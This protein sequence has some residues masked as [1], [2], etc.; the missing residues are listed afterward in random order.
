MGEMKKNEYDIDSYGDEAGDFT[1]RWDIHLHTIIGSPCAAY[2]PLQIPHYAKVEKL[3]G[4]VITDHNFGWAEDDVTV[5]KY[6]E[7]FRS[8]EE[9][10]V[11][12]FL[13]MEVTCK[14]N[15][16]LVYTEDI[17]K[18]LKSLPG[19][20]GRIDFD[21]EEVI[22]VVEEVGGLSVLAHPHKYPETT[23]VEFDAIERY[24]GARG[25]FYNPY[26]I[27]EVAG[28]DAHFPWGVGKACT[29]FAE[30]IREITDLIKLVKGGRCR[31]VR[32]KVV[33]E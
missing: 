13:G 23:K 6:D 3:E 14:E 4:V 9:S 17:I 33:F 29:A 5:D 10:G 18:F 7:L 27:P 25:V 28:S 8:F 11:R 16:I 12:V 21:L 32:K 19:G 15:D 24:N 2:D 20:V 22:E 1:H 30:E 31:P 26:G